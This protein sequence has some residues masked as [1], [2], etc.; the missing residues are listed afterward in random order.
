MDGE[1]IGFFF[2]PGRRRA[3][4]EMTDASHKTPR[5]TSMASPV[6]SRP[7]SPIP[8]SELYPTAA[9]ARR[10]LVRSEIAI[11]ELQGDKWKALARNDHG[12]C[13]LVITE[14]ARV[15]Y[16][17]GLLRALIDITEDITDLISDYLVEHGFAE[18][19]NDDRGG[20]PAAH[21]IGSF[22][23]QGLECAVTKY[24]V[25]G[26]HCF[27]PVYVHELLCDALYALRK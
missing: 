26:N 1:G 27:R 13:T 6:L 23:D 22:L 2:V 24:L 16:E 12:A 8:L 18:K 9:S 14:I 11:L 5:R 17:L 15:T 3:P 10:A 25:D 19:L 7:A 20:A 4:G 21:I